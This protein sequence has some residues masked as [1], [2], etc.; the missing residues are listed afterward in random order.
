MI[1]RK[2]SKNRKVDGRAFRLNIG[3]LGDRLGLSD[4]VLIILLLG[5]VVLLLINF[6]LVVLNDVL[7]LATVLG[8][9]VHLLHVVAWC[10]HL[11]LD[12][13][14]H[15]LRARSLLLPFATFLGSSL[16]KGSVEL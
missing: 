13:S 9:L 7:L 16:V 8:L 5:C 14:A 4:F 12:H 2:Q 6:F 11:V 15:L 1:L 10:E 3:S